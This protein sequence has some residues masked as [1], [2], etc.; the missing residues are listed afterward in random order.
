MNLFYSSILRTIQISGHRNP[1]V[2][3]N[4]EDLCNF[5]VSNFTLSTKSKQVCGMKGQTVYVECLFNVAAAMELSM[6]SPKMESLENPCLKT[7]HCFCSY[8]CH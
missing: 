8:F 4:E 6:L 7:L 2:F 3:L 5:H 1:F